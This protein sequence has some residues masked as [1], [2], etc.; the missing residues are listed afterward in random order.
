MQG[1]QIAFSDSDLAATAAAYDP[2]K[3]EAPI[4]IGHPTLDAPAYGWVGK[5]LAKSGELDVTAEQVDPV[6][7]ELVAAG[8][9]K[10]ISAAFYLPDSPSNPVPG[11]YYLKHVGFLGAQPPAIK[12]LRQASFAAN[13]EGVVEFADW[14]DMQNAGLWRSLRDFFIGKFGLEDADKAIPNWSIQNL[15]DSARANDA[16][17]PFAEPTT[18]P[19]TPKKEPTTVTDEEK[20]KLEAENSQMKK[21]LAELEAKQKADEKARQEAEHTAFAESLTKHGKLEPKRVPVVVAALNAFASGETV[22][23]GEGDNKTSLAEEF[24]ALLTDRQPV[25]TF[26]EIA[27]ID[28]VSG[29]PLQDTA[30]FGEHNVDADRMAQDGAIRKH[31][32]E[33]K[34]DYPTAARAIIR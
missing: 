12:G 2:A 7:A 16:P 17:V 6:F 28:K 25:I 11:V 5:V 33:H 9:Y 14:A 13:E 21:R 31:M 3:H 24:K 18:Q 34:V 27:T 15:E 8:R 19:P 30:H 1:G 26:G 32:A 20:A 4:V 29:Q 22:T 23:F 10:K